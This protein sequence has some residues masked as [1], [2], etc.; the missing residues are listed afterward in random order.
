MEAIEVLL[1]TGF[2]VG[3]KWYRNAGI[4]PLN[5]TDEETMR[6]IAQVLLPVKRITILLTRC[7]TNLGPKTA[8]NFDDVYSLTVGDRDALL[9]LLR[10]LI[11][12][13]KI[14]SVLTC[15]IV[16]CVKKMDLELT[17]GD[18]LVPPNQNAR[19]VYE[20][21][22]SENGTTYNVKF[23]LPTGA[24]QVEAA[25]LAF[26]DPD[27]ASNLM[28]L[29]C[30]Q[31]VK[32]EDAKIRIKNNPP[33]VVA[34]ALPKIMTELDPQAEILLDMT[35]P[36]CNQSF[37]ANFDIGDY[38]FRE[39]INHSQQLYHEVHV[40]ALHYHWNERDILNMPRAKRQIYL[41]LLAE[42]LS[43]E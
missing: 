24:D 39:L 19:E 12:G 23:R 28:L 18:I 36:S 5:G 3:N 41:N 37:T 10:R 34:E 21:A 31:E 22:I 7:L 42:T 11:Y 1:P 2:A 9:L 16:S 40:L 15:P 4:R 27:A 32:R 33:K 38:L 8:I 29:R 25:K 17:I 6:E 43:S 14:Q 26:H 35:C 20:R 30:I 13:D